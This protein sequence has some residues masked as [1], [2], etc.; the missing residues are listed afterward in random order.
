VITRL[1]RS[2]Y[3]SAVMGLLIFAASPDAMSLRAA[4][5]DEA[6]PWPEVTE[7]ERRPEVRPAGSGGGRGHPAPDTLGK[8][9]RGKSFR[10]ELPRY[11]W[12]MKILI[13]RQEILRSA[14]PLVQ[15]FEVSG[16]E[17]RTISRTHGP[18]GCA[19]P[20]L[21]EAGRKGAGV[22]AHRNS[23]S[24]PR[25]WSRAPSSSIGT[26]GT[27]AASS[28]SSLA[29]AVRVHAL[30]PVSQAVHEDHRVQDPV[31]QVSQSGAR[32]DALEEG[33][34][35]GKLLT[36]EMRMSPLQGGT[37]DAAVAEVSPRIEMV[38]RARGGAWAAL[39]GRTILHG[40][41][42]GSEIHA[43]LLR[44]GLQLDESR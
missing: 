10:D 4:V 21:R 17:A 6:V 16:I 22:Q 23:C 34:V 32:V 35:K 29:L 9:R 1:L 8:D 30:L 3:A 40:L 2:K 14:H 5:K 19:G 37:N 38:L 33:K 28:T 11:H 15:V 42:F 39:G 44:E 18:A 26:N 7:Q 36:V 31:R 12:R 13:K 27:S 43:L 24:I 25:S 41:G 20:D